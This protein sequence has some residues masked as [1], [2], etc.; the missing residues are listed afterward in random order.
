MKKAFSVNL[1]NGAANETMLLQKITL[2][3]DKKAKGICLLSL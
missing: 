2:G 3:R 1:T